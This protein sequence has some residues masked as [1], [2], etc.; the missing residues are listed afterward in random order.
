[1]P[2]IPNAISVYRFIY[3]VRIGQISLVDKGDDLRFLSL[4]LARKDMHKA[5]ALRKQGGRFV[6]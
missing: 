5:S 3:D 1:M 4:H 6:C 2:L